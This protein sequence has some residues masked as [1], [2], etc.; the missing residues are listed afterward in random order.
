MKGNFIHVAKKNPSPYLLPYVS[1]NTKNE[2]V[3]VVAD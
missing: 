1:F 2:L 3:N